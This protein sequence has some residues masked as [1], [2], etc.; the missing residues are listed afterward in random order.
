MPW[1]VP[2]AARVKLGGHDTVRPVAGVAD[3]VSV[4]VPTKPFGLAGRLFSVTVVEPVKPELKL[5]AVGFAVI[6]KS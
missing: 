5:T 6:L 2:P 1:T 4:T 3:V